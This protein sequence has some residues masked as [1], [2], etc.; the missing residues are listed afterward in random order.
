MIDRTR[1][2]IDTPWFNTRGSY[3]SPYEADAKR[4]NAELANGQLQVNGPDGIGMRIFQNDYNQNVYLESL[5]QRLEALEADPAWEQPRNRE[6]YIALQHEMEAVHAVD[7]S[8]TS[9]VFNDKLT[10]LW[11]RAKADIVTGDPEPGPNH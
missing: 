4:W 7:I 8:T 6:A 3:P 5:E 1:Y 10:M 11:D 9:E 2:A